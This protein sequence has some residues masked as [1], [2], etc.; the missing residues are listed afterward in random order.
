MNFFSIIRFSWSMFFCILVGVSGSLV[1]RPLR[2]GT[3]D[4]CVP[5]GDPAI[6]FLDDFS[7]SEPLLR[8][9]VANP[10]SAGLS[11][12]AV[13]INGEAVTFDYL[14]GFGV[15]G[16][17]YRG[18]FDFRRCSLEGDIRFETPPSSPSLPR[19]LG[20]LSW[21]DGASQ[22]G[23]ITLGL[24]L[25]EQRIY[26]IASGA[27]GSGVG[28]AYFA[29][30]P[31][32]TYRAR[33]IVEPPS[34]I[35]AYVNNTLVT[36]LVYS[37]LTGFPSEMNPDVGA[38]AKA[39][40]RIAHDNLTVRSLDTPPAPLAGPDQD[41][42]SSAQAATVIMGTASDG[43]GEPLQYRWFDGE[44]ELQAWAVVDGSGAASL[45]LATVPLLTRGLH[46]L[47]LEVTDGILTVSDCMELVIRN[48][49]PVATVSLVSSQIEVG[50]DPIEVNGLV[51]DFDGGDVVY[52]W[53]SGDVELASGEVTLPSGGGEVV[54]PGPDIPAGDAAFPVGSYTLRLV[55]IDGE[56]GNAS[57]TVPVT[58]VDTQPPVL[59][60]VASVT[61]LW[62][63]S[64]DMRP[65]SIL[66]GAS[67][68]SVS[69]LDLAVRVF[70]SEPDTG[71][72]NGRFA[73]DS[74][75]VSVD[76]ASGVIDLLLRA[77]RL[78]R[79]TGRTYTVVITA[80]DES[81]NQTQAFVLVT[82]PSDLR[83]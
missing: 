17:A 37:G 31:G 73:P 29:L 83:R 76:E 50:V 61:V 59:K 22:N 58:V 32:V 38:N 52:R 66:A 4:P 1:M 2:G 49:H 69:P 45:D 18:K 12:M 26:I 51:S 25:D 21:V 13:G 9:T 81:D 70:S 40:V 10:P 33:L 82:V 57:A 30:T 27:G 65:V 63:P 53:F 62:P 16:A 5:A 60:P 8:Y 56:G 48:A 72:G 68:N 28:S 3:V 39:S 34:T 80:T 35:K 71:A 55:V 79:V 41:I 43:D 15:A 36:T 47:R 19:C 67:D 20:G 54:V 42:I 24:Q 78:S 14:S 7:M 77:E 64:R 44:D 11:P 23:A 75:V 6:L 46:T 74:E